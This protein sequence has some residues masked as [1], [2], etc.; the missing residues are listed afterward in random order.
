[1]EEY[2]KP[3]KTAVKVWRLKRIIGMAVMLAAL[4]PASVA[5]YFIMKSNIVMMGIIYVV[6]GLIIIFYG[7]GIFVFPAIEYRQWKYL[8]SGEKVEIVHGI[9]FIRRDIIPVIRM[10]NITIK[11]GPIYRK[12]HL[13]TVEIALASGTFEIIGL[14]KETAREIADKLRERLYIRLEK[15]EA[16]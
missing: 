10:Q 1:M 12:Y 4:I 5:V 14:S 16:L 13:Y 9:F 2:K 11:Q 3:E 8:I 7:V 6:I 15:E